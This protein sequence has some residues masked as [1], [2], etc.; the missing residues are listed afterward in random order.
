MPA[1]ESIATVQSMLTQFFMLCDPALNLQ[2][3]SGKIVVFD[4]YF[5]S[6]EKKVKFVLVNNCLTLSSYIVFRNLDY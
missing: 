1:T 2:I 4:D 5:L 3:L 6:K